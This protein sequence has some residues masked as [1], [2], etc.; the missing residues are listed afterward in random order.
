[1][2]DLGNFQSLVL[3]TEWVQQRD[4]FADCHAELARGDTVD[5]GTSRL[6]IWQVLSHGQCRE[7]LLLEVVEVLFLVRQL[8]EEADRADET[9]LPSGDDLAAEFQKFL[10]EERDD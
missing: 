10:R 6:E 2:L 5:V 3:G 1:M 7:L 4:R 8:E 9:D